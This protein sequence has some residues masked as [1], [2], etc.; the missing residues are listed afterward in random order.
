MGMKIF[1][2]VINGFKIKFFRVY[3]C[4]GIGMDQ[5]TPMYYKSTAWQ[6]LGPVKRKRKTCDT[7]S[8]IFK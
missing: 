7:V 1:Y 4:I 3:F 5:I 6:S 2:R 8:E